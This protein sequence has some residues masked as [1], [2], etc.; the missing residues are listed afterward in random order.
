MKKTYA[1]ILLCLTPIW[2]L[3]QVGEHRNQFA[4]GF[5]AGYNLNKVDFVPKVNQTFH[6]GYT[7]GLSLRYVCEKYF[8]SICS[9]YGVQL[10]ATRM[11]R[12]YP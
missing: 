4:V 9:I 11:E 2:T 1:L 5:Q 10:L 8:N 3:A 7:G 6:G 12:G